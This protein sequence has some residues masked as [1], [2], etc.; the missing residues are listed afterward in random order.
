MRSWSRSETREKL[1]VVG[2]R[3]MKEREK[4]I[5]GDPELLSR[6]LAYER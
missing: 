3:H 5:T 6:K 2:N 1:D 4:A